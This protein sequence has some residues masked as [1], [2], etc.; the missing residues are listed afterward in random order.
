MT[1]QAA[2][3]HERSNDGGPKLDGAPL[4]LASASPRRRKILEQL[5]VPFR[6]HV[7]GAEEIAHA[8]DPGQTVRANALAKVRATRSL[9]PE[10]AIIAA[11][12]VI[13]FKG[14]CLG[15]PASLDDARR[16]LASLSGNAHTV[17][18]GVALWAA[19]N[20]QAAT[21]KVQATVVRFRRFQTRD[22]E[23]YIREVN[24][25]DKAGGYDIDQSGQ[26]IIDSVAGSRTNVMG[27]PIEVVRPWLKQQSLL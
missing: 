25:L 13:E 14:R 10:A 15:K 5:G 17:W 27:L 23:A 22:V 11:D 18:T 4:Y 8:S 24:P 2:A 16:M 21:I 3:A 1:D 6:V 26:M 20:T 12:T 9:F 19:G 7:T